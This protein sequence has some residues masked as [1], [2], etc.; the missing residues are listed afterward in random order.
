MSR[1]PVKLMVTKSH[2]GIREVPL[3]DTVIYRFRETGDGPTGEGLLASGRFYPGIKYNGRIFY[4]VHQKNRFIPGIFW[5]DRF[6]PGL[7]T[8]RGFFPGLAVNSTF[9]PGIVATGVFMPGIVRG[10]SF[11][12]GLFSNQEHF[13][14]GCFTTNRGFVPGR[15]TRQGFECGLM[16]DGEFRATAYE[17]L[18]TRDAHALHEGGYGLSKVRWLAPIG[19][20]PI[21]GMVI[22][23]FADAVAY[24]PYGMAT[25]QGVILGGLKKREGL[26][27]KE[28]LSALDLEQELGDAGF[29][30]H[31]PKDPGQL[32]GTDG[33][34]EK[35]EKRID[36][37]SPGSGVGDSGFAPGA[38]LADAM[39]GMNAGENKLIDGLNQGW[40]DYYSSLLGANA[41]GMIAGSASA[42]VPGLGKAVGGLSGAYS[43]AKGG[44][45]I[46]AFAGP[47]GVVVGGVVGMIGGAVLG[48]ATNGGDTIVDTV[49]GVAEAVWGFFA[50]IFGGGEK[51]EEKKT[52]DKPKNGKTAQ[53]GEDGLGEGSTGA[54]TNRPV[55]P[56]Y[57]YISRRK[58]VIEIDHGEAGGVST[59][60][61]EEP[62]I[63]IIRTDTGAMS[64]VNFEALRKML[65]SNPDRRAV[66]GLNPVTG[67]SVYIP[68]R[69]S[70][71]EAYEQSKAPWYMNPAVQPAPEMQNY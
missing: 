62:A 31:D 29:E 32:L 41:G 30:V 68:G 66:V 42:D 65:I 64:V 26:E 7:M 35:I 25:D 22:G 9:T 2:D 24:L 40:T 17:V 14:P 48:V 69:I 5:C 46:G 67:E 3:S 53:P 70:V 71:K 21:R 16:A 34:I 51:K 43:G 18:S 45:A 23:S 63:R 57:P 11:I 56:L 38:R 58:T 49:V 8:R 12:P 33:L 52:E 27:P 1:T 28:V 44:M 59:V 37:F 55:K 50:G 60:D 19:G 20:L 15:F 61:Y 4:G 10:A 36:D 6:I 47:I 39:E 54:V 13:Q